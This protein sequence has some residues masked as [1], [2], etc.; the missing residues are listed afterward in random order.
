MNKS[1]FAYKN[2]VLN[3]EFNKYLVEHPEMTDKMPDN[4]LVV[5]LPDDDPGLCRKNL[6][7]ARRHREQNQPIVYVRIKKLAPP[8]K[9]T[10]GATA[11]KDSV[12]EGAGENS[13]I[14]HY[15]HINPLISEIVSPCHPEA[16]AEGSRFWQKLERD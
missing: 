14:I 8:S 11:I 16:L 6:T 1:S 12:V 3:S 15:P 5:M 7:L 9:V 10:S 13:F 2:I 4:A